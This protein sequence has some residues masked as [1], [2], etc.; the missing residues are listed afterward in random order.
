M[1]NV[2]YAG[3]KGSHNSSFHLVSSLPGDK[4]F[5]TNFFRGILK[6]IESLDAGYKNVSVIPGLQEAEG[7][8]GGIS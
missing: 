1:E 5:L 6:D 2:L 3:F 4:V 7:E 8:Y